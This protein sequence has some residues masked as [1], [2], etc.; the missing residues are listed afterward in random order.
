MA[1]LK[2]HIPV[3]GNFQK[4]CSHSRFLLAEVLT[5][6]CDSDLRLS[7]QCCWKFVSSGKL[8]HVGWQ[9]F[10]DDSKESIFFDANSV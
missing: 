2:G 5:K 9:T 4:F 3:D 1:V 10:F 6:L 7:Q 8:H